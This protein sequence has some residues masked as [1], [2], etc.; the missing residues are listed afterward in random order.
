MIALK[1]YTA[2]AE[3]GHM[4]CDEAV[5]QKTCAEL[6]ATDA[7]I[8]LQLMHFPTQVLLTVDREMHRTALSLGLIATNLRYIRTA[9]R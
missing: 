7:A 5:A 2:N 4:A 3:E 9:Y 1:E 6:G 8:L